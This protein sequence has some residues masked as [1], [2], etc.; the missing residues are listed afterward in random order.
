MMKI[1][2]G[3]SL[4]EVLD[5]NIVL[6]TGSEAYMPNCIMSVNETGAVLWH[7]LE[8]GAERAELVACLLDAFEVDEATTAHDVD[9]FIAQLQEKALIEAC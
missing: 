2:S 4:R 6:G 3:Y 9:G 5:T 8:Q 7:A 1:R